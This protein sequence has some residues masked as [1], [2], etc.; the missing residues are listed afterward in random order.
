MRLFWQSV[1]ILTLALT[2][3]MASPGDGRDDD[4][5][6]K[7]A[8]AASA[9]ADNTGK[10][11]GDDA[12]ATPELSSLELEVQQLRE[13]LAGQARQLREQNEQLQQQQQ[14]LEVLAGRLQALSTGRD[15][16]N[17]LTAGGLAL[18]PV[19]PPGLVAATGTG[20]AAAAT[21]QAAQGPQAQDEIGRRIEERVARIG[22]FT[23]SGDF[24]LRDEP[25][26]GGSS[27]QAQARHR[28]RLRARLFVNARL[29]DEISGGLALASGHLGDAISANQD[30]NEFFSRKP[31]DLDR[32]FITYTPR[33]FRQMSLT[34][35]K[36]AYPW[37]RTELTWDNDLNPEGVTQTLNF[38]LPNTPVLKRFAVVSFVLPFAETTGVN[39]NFRPGDNN[40]S[41]RQS[42]VYGGQLQ[43]EWQLTGRLKLS[44]YTAFYNWHNADPVAFSTAAVNPASPATGSVRL[45]GFNLQNS[46]TVWTQSTTVP[47]SAGGTTGVNTS[48][49]NAQFGSK[50]G[51]L[52]TIA[53]FDI[54]TSSPKWPVTL[55]ADFVQNTKACSNAENF[56]VPTPAAGATITATT[57]VPCDPRQ[58][59]AYWLEGRL[60][61][62]TEQ[63]DWQFAYTRMFIEREAVLGAYNFSDLRQNSNVSQHRV[64]TFYNMHRNVQLGFTGL[65]GRPLGSSA[66][67]ETILKR[68]QFDVLYRF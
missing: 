22:P 8:A 41:V 48:I 3:V 5:A 11:R 36:F 53:R 68:L 54:Q 7:G 29:N 61:R 27:S 16:T 40:R 34:G 4:S 19:T 49:L 17:A 65:F 62:A 28:A 38:A 50:F 58:R 52:D 44:A 13:V 31:F 12:G 47:T 2:P 43:T 14:A 33:W 39:F 26:F 21:P 35:G 32:A 51:L 67:A 15:G 24:R 60:G 9:T 37:Y 30:L 45:L 57:T 66:P 64:E 20:I 63:G 25:F 56:L 42:V 1:L 6:T 18:N 23:F 59:Q 55:L 46:V 10:A